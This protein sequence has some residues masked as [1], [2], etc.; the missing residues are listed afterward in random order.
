MSDAL[1]PLLIGGHSVGPLT[2]DE[3]RTSLASGSVDRI[4]SAESRTAR[5][6]KRSVLD[7]AGLGRLFTGG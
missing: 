3:V 1:W 4:V 2:A 5:S 6:E 7:G